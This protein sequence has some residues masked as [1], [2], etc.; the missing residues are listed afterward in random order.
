MR[1]WARIFITLL[2]LLPT[3]AGSAGAEMLRVV[4]LPIIVHSASADA[5]YVSGGLADMLSSRLE[6]LGEIRVIRRD[7][8]GTSQLEAAL[9]SGAEAGGDY[10]I[11]G[12]FTQFGDGASLDVHCAPLGDIEEAA[13]RRRIF[14][15]SGNVSEI[16]PKL[17]TLVDRIAHYLNRPASAPAPGLPV[18]PAPESESAVAGVAEAE[19]VGLRDRIDALEQAV[20]G[21]AEQAPDDASVPAEEASPES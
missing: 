15:Q 19:L 7:E 1:A 16:I 20:Y 21:L 12:A 14:V 5:G 11:Y 3:L 13:A 10:V 4:M 17:D 8:G 18:T 9:E 6:L 2:T